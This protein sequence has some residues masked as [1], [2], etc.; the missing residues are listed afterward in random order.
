[1]LILLIGSCQ[2]PAATQR[3][4]SVRITPRL[5]GLRRF[6]MTIGDTVRFRA[7]VLDAAGQPVTVPVQWST[8]NPALLSIDNGGLAR[9][10]ASFAVCNSGFDARVPCFAVVIA[11]AGGVADTLT[12]TIHARAVVVFELPVLT[13]RPGDT[14]TVQRYP[15]IEG[16]PIPFCIPVAG[17]SIDST[18]AAVPSDTRSTWAYDGRVIGVR[19]GRTEIVV[20]YRCPPWARGSLPV[21]VTE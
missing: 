4:A 19:H 13:L 18:I 2:D 20:S 7:E 9:T 1:M 21:I 10:A 5:E 15:A 17:E 12:V 3:V 6:P 16:R 11:N 8:L 14:I